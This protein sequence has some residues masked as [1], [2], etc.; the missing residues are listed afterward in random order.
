MAKPAPKRCSISRW[1]MVARSNG[2]RRAASRMN[3]IAG[4]RAARGPRGPLFSWAGMLAEARA[5][6]QGLQARYDANWYGY[7]AK[8]RLDTMDRNGNVPRK[9][10][11]ADSPIGRAVANLQTVSVAEETAGRNEDERIAKADQLS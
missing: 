8:Q 6:Y 1:P 11:A 4:F 3:Y 5:I 9:D 10:F 7:L 2:P